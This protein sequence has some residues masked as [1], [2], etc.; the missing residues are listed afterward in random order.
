M[1]ESGR[2]SKRLAWFGYVALSAA[3]YGVVALPGSPRVD[4][5]GLVFSLLLD[6]VIIAGLIGARA[7]AWWLALVRNGLA[8]LF[9]IPVLITEW[10]IGWSALG[11][12]DVLIVLTLLYFRPAFAT[13]ASPVTTTPEAP[14]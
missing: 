13:R 14:A 5:R 3:Y 6:A 11:V 8:L 1:D 10:S 7:W 4:T 12:I 9:C 2:R